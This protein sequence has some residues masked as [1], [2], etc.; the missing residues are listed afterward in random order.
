M[1]G[2]GY[3][4]WPCTDEGPE[5]QGTQYL[6]KGQIFDRPNGKAEF[7]ACDWE[8]NGRSLKNSHWYFLQYVKLVTTPAVLWLVTAVHLRHF[9]DEPDS[10]KWTIKTP[11][12]W[13]LKTTTWF[14]LSSSW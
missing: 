14:G 12:S 10:Y 11:K 6:Y 9:A 2:M 4:Q 1:E 7:F 3:I 8:P 13:V 5:D